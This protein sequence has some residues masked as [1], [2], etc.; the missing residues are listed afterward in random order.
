MQRMKVAGIYKISHPSTGHFYVGKSTDIA[1]R[2]HT[3]LCDFLCKRH[4]ETMQELW[5]SSHY[6]NWTFSILKICSKKELLEM[7][8]KFI[9]EAADKV[10]ADGD[11]SLFLNVI[12]NRHK[13]KSASKKTDKKT[14]KKVN[15]EIFSNMSTSTKNAMFGVEDVNFVEGTK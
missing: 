9:E 2:W 5:D 1:S 4:T 11:T 14:D 13:K 6:T 8:K 10:E 15:E 7:E 3:H 12:G